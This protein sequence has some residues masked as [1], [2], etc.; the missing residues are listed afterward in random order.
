M[1]SLKFVERRGNMIY[2]EGDFK[3]DVL[4]RYLGTMV[5]PEVADRIVSMINKE[6]YT[7]QQLKRIN[8]LGKKLKKTGTGNTI[9]FILSYMEANIDE[10]VEA[11]S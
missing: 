9:N 5:S 8:E 11:S 1:N 3:N 7:K 10:A 6:H 2:T 4:A